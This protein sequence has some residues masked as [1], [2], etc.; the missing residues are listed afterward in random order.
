MEYG[1]LWILLDVSNKMLFFV[2]LI[3]QAEQ[4]FVL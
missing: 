2:R 1:S 3:V 4:V